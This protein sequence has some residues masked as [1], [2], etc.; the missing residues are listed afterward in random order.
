[1]EQGTGSQIKG[2]VP[3]RLT[4]T[5]TPTLNLSKYPDDFKISS[6][7]EQYGCGNDERIVKKEDKM[8]NIKKHPIIS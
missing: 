8:K 3:T 2:G 5:T 7:M 1:M 4:N 6:G